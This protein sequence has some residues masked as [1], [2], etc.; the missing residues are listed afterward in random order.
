[1]GFTDAVSQRYRRATVGCSYFVRSQTPLLFLSCIYLCALTTD[2]ENDD[3]LKCSLATPTAAAK[4]MRAAWDA[5]P[6]LERIVQD[7]LRVL[8]ALQEV[9]DVD[10]AMVPNERRHGRR[11]ESRYAALLVNADFVQA[12]ATRNGTPTPSYGAD[13]DSRGSGRECLRKHLKWANNRVCSA[14]GRGRKR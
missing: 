10:G 2:L 5:A 3:P 13:E 1:M 14:E 11:A 8:V 9:M 7:I 4:T 12:Q 6:T